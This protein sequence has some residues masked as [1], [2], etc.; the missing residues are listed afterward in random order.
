MINMCKVVGC[1]YPECREQCRYFI[2]VI[3][4]L[5]ELRVPPEVQIEVVPTPPKPPYIDTYMTNMWRLWGYNINLEKHKK[6]TED[7]IN[8][9]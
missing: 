1:P 7:F 8:Q 2:S 9:F 6:N 4:Q 3:R 5:E